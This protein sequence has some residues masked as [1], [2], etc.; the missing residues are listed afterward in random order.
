MRQL[1][2]AGYSIIELLAVLTIL[3]I[4]AALVYPSFFSN[5]SDRQVQAAASEV[6]NAIRFARSDAIASGQHRAVQLQGNTTVSVSSVDNSVTPPT[7]NTLVRHPLT[8]QDFSLQL[9]ELEHTRGVEFVSAGEA[10]ANGASSSTDTLFFTPQGRPYVI[11]S[12]SQVVAL[13]GVDLLVQN[14]QFAISFAVNPVSGRVT[15]SDADV[16]P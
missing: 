14:T 11:D 8:R 15:H 4:S 16:V 7:I 13:Q 12:S 9:S 5:N 3:V 6:V 2:G 10:F 1:Q